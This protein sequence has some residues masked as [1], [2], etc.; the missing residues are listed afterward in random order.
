MGNRFKNRLY[1][2]EDIKRI[3]GHLQYCQNA[4]G[5]LFS[6]PYKT[7]IK[8]KDLPEWYL[9]GRYYKRFGYMSAQGIT[10]MVYLPDLL[11]NHFLKDDCLLIS[12][13]GKIIESNPSAQ[14]RLERYSGYDEM[15]WGNE[16][17]TMLRGARK[18][19]DFDIKPFIEKIQEKKEWLQSAHSDE[20]GP[21]RWD[22]DIDLLFIDQLDCPECNKPLKLMRASKCDD[23]GHDVV[24]HC[25]WCLQ[26][27]EWYCDAQGW[28]KDMKRFFHG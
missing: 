3:D 27:W 15:V 6:G 1:T 21:D 7:K 2:I 26:D 5:S 8:P 16:I 17:L 4:D 28:S 22:V 14:F 19:S 23:G 20:F 12:F 11:F 10:D 25:V 13:G 18:Y 9:Y 24:G